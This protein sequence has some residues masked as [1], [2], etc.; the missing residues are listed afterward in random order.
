MNEILTSLG[1]ALRCLL[2][3]RIMRVMIWPLV[4]A[5]VLWAVVAGVFWGDWVQLMQRLVES[6]ALEHVISTS[7]LA[8][9]GAALAWV[10]VL[11]LYLLFVLATA[12][13]VTAVIGMPAMVSMI[14]ERYYP[15]L[16]RAKGGTVAG[17]LWSATSATAIFVVLLILSV[18][19]WFLVPFGGVIFPLL[20][21]GWLN[22]RLFRY[23]ALAEHATPNEYR[24]LLRECRG[25]LYGLGL[26]LAALQVL[27][28]FTLILIPVVLFFVPVFSGL[29]FIHLALGRLQAMRRS[30]LEH[31]PAG[32]VAID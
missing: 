31:G 7:V 30:R 28:S 1:V 23:D 21:N 12:L 10:L 19:L 32:Q 2:T 8:F 9:V 18:P 3:R 25:E 13:I 29:A 22:T 14:A 27:P 4:G 20:I 24:A 26:V 16:E 6:R 15:E 5:I 11:P 17:S